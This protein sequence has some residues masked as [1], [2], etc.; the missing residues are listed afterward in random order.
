ME[1]KKQECNGDLCGDNEYCNKSS[2]D[3]V[4]VC[5]RKVGH[6]GNHISCSG[7]DHNMRIW[8]QKKRKPKPKK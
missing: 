1:I 8:N 7:S 5:T 2:P 4:Y 6:T 3:G